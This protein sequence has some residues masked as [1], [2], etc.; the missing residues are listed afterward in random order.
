MS[1]LALRFNVSR[2]YYL[3]VSAERARRPLPPELIQRMQPRRGAPV[4]CSTDELVALNARVDETFTNVL[5]ITSDLLTSLRA[6]VRRRINLLFKLTDAVGLLD[7]LHA[8]AAV[9]T[10]AST[11]RTPW[12]RPRLSARDHPEDE[13][14]PLRILQ[15]RG[16]LLEHR[17]RRACVPNDFEV[18]ATDLAEDEGVSESNSQAPDRSEAAS[19]AAGDFEDSASLFAVST[20]SDDFVPARRA[21]ASSVAPSEPQSIPFDSA[22]LLPSVPSSSSSSSSSSAALGGAPVRPQPTL[23]VLVGPNS[24]GKS[25]FLR[26]VAHVVLLAHLGSFVPAERADLAPLTRLCTRLGAAA[27]DEEAGVSSFL[28]EMRELAS[29]LDAAHSPSERALVL[30][31]ELGR[32]TCTEDGVSIAWAAAEELVARRVP[33]VFVTHFHEL[34]H[35]P[36]LYPGR[37]AVLSTSVVTDPLNHQLRFFFR[38]EPAVERV[39]RDYGIQ[40]ARESGLPAELVALAGRL[41]SVLSDSLRDSC[42]GTG[43]TTVLHGA[44]SELRPLLPLAS[45]SDETGRDAWRRL[46]VSVARRH[47]GFLRRWSRRLPPIPAPATRAASARPSDEDAVVQEEPASASS[48]ATPLP[49]PP[50]TPIEPAPPSLPG[51]PASTEE[52]RSRPSWQD[53]FGLARRSELRT[54]PRPSPASADDPS[55]RRRLGRD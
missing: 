52:A 34:E 12:V 14:I 5:L 16:P 17:Q 15:G 50:S 33:A 4:L 38:V 7:M 49:D 10:R 43:A 22:V 37:A 47:A 35:L 20:G 8:F 54:P 3:A 23:K 53:V 24:S 18:F 45:A 36:T 44:L 32:G 25:T 55:K 9:A 19:A 41:R 51:A 48:P 27:D 11:A 39:E 40:L 31:D 46:L 21:A 13:C 28:A 26:M 42:A 2:G 30:V 1:D 29:A 6:S